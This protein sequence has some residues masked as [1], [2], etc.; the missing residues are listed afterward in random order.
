MAS[1]P[2]LDNLLV[3]LDWCHLRPPDLVD[4]CQSAYWET[5]ES[6][7]P[8][9]TRTTPLSVVVQ[10]G[11]HLTKNDPVASVRE[12][13]AGHASPPL[14]DDYFDA[15]WGLVLGLVRRAQDRWVFND[16]RRLW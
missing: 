9:G 1:V 12:E 15:W 6:G 3:S 7:A 14:L 16:G 11:Y 5:G 2:T 4:C 13:Q 8:C 10:A